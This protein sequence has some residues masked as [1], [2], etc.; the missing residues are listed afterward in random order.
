MD[1]QL[2][3]ASCA[4][5]AADAPD[6]CGAP[7]GEDCLPGCPSLATDDAP[8]ATVDRAAF[9]AA[10]PAALLAVGP[11]YM[12]GTL[13]PGVGLVRSLDLGEAAAAAAPFYTSTGRTPAAIRV[14]AD[15]LSPGWRGYRNE[16]ARETALSDA[17]LTLEFVEDHAS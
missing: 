10:I 15:V 12:G 3:Y 9:E 14:A 8:T 16:G 1:N 11:A 6:L 17:R 4:D 2:A 7:A 13:I 5:A